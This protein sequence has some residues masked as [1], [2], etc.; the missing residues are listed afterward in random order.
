M[1]RRTTL[2]SPWRE[3]AE[4]AGGVAALATSLGVGV[5]TLRSWAAGTRHPGAITRASVA[6]WARR[7]GM[8]PPW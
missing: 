3:M 6:A 4:R 7:R 8:A 2:A 5:S 1:S